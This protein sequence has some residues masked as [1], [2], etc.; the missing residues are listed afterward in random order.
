MKLINLRRRVCGLFHIYSISSF[1]ILARTPTK[2]IMNTINVAVAK[3]QDATWVGSGGYREAR[4]AMLS[5]GDNC[6]SCR[7]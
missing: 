1:H 4:R 6:P 2:Y 7:Y 5:G 3:E